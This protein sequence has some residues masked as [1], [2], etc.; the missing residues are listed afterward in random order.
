M[1]EEKS[2]RPMLIKN[3]LDPFNSPDYIY[4]LKLDGIRCIAYLNETHTELRNK[5]N[6]RIL[7]KFPELTDIHANAK[8]KCILDGELVILKK[9]VPDFLEIQRRTLM[10]DRLQIGLAAAKYPSCYVAYDLLYMNNKPLFNLPLIERKRLL[11]GI[12]NENIKLAVSRYVTEHGVE[13]FNLAKQQNLEGV[14]AKVWNSRYYPDKHSKE[15]VKFKTLADK[16]FVI[17]GYVAKEKGATSLIL[18]Q[19]RGNDLLYKGHVIKGVHSGFASEYNCTSI[20]Q[21]PFRLT[22]SGNEDAIWLEPR[23]VCTVQYMPNEKD[24]L[25]Q[26]VLKG[27]RNDKAPSDCRE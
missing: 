6:E 11:E 20:S 9:G 5:R 3:I 21:S 23:L 27:I 14:V 22:P 2:I 25:R 17:C 19:Y 8:G 18:G 15:W 12:I 4:E 1:F 16:D 13:L 26:P 24:V 7:S 10:N